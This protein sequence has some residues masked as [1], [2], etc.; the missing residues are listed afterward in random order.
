MNIYVYIYTHK[1]E[2]LGSSNIYIHKYE[3]EKKGRGLDCARAWNGS[4]NL[5]W[6]AKDGKG[7]IIELLDKAHGGYLH[8]K[9]V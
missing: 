8:W 7:K 2:R 1:Y 3:D 5:I 6:P 9:K 4:Q